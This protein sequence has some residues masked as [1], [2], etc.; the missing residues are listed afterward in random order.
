MKVAIIGDC[1]IGAGS[2]SP[3][4]SLLMDRFFTETFFPYLKKNNINTLIQLGDL[5]DKRKIIDFTSLSEGK[6]YFFDPL[7]KAN[8]ESHV[9]IGNH[10]SYFRNTIEINAP[11][12]LLG[13]YSN[14]H[15]YDKPT[16][17]N[18]DGCS[19]D[20][21]PWICKENEEESFEFI[22]NS[23]SVICC[24]HLEVNGF[25]M[26]K[27]MESHGGIARDIF[28]NYDSV[29]S[30]HYHTRSVSDQSNI[31][32]LGTPYELTWSDYNDQKGF[33]IFDTDTRELEFIP[34]PH[35]I[36]IRHE[37][38]DELNNYTN[39]DITPFV[40]KYIKIVVTKKTDFYV[41]DRFLRSLYEADT[42]GIKILEDLSDL[43]EGSVDTDKVDIENTLEV[44][45]SFVDSV[46]EDE[47]KDKIKNFMK[48]LYLEA[49][50]AQS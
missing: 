42:Y 13:E 3:Q 20:M 6:R 25:S 21:L 40:Q 46:A 2:S 39:F 28:K 24:G 17:I 15:T 4:L 43:T 49:I 50:G 7:H 31:K 45:E 29:F 12:L 23:T 8:I 33:H 10:D 19:I 22:R 14:I 27:G 48:G 41:F 16:T 9:I 5:F 36:F 32:Y 1:H 37:Y 34:S 30:G 35:D 11:S 18:I 47:K 26:A 38:N 44:L